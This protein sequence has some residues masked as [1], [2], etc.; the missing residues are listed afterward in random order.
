MSQLP[1][2]KPRCK[3]GD[4]FCSG[5]DAQPEKDD[6][7][8]SKRQP[9]KLRGVVPLSAEEAV[10][11]ITRSSLAA[12]RRHKHASIV[13][14]VFLTWLM[15]LKVV[16]G[17]HRGTWRGNFAPISMPGQGR[18]EGRIAIV[19]TF[20]L[21][22]AMAYTLD[23]PVGDATEPS[24]WWQPL[25]FGFA[26]FG[27][28][29]FLSAFVVASAGKV[30]YQ[31]LWI[32][33]LFRCAVN[34]LEHDLTCNPRYL[35]VSNLRRKLEAMAKKGAIIDRMHLLSTLDEVSRI[36]GNCRPTIWTGCP[37][38]EYQ[39]YYIPASVSAL[40][41][42]IAAMNPGAVFRVCYHLSLAWAFEVTDPDL[43]SNELTQTWLADN[44]RLFSNNDYGLREVIV[45]AAMPAELSENEP[46]VTPSEDT[47][48]SQDD[49]NVIAMFCPNYS[50]RQPDYSVKLAEITG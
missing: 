48:T 7:V 24:G 50:G 11:F 17:G 41:D 25:L 29:L 22:I 27:V 45:A 44:K 12:K 35:D 49:W 9:G 47:D 10:D 13:L 33:F 20:F 6:S 16:V 4:S 40:V 46:N 3:T 36:A 1:E 34:Y 39:R 14:Q 28:S 2:R 31:D 32:P 18:L 8:R 15:A 37:Y 23:R 21:A 43:Q 19:A 42:Q 38:N 26:L 30:V 5:E